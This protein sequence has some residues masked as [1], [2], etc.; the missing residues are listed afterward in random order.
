VNRGYESMLR[1]VC[2]IVFC[3]VSWNACSQEDVPLHRES[4]KQMSSHV[5]FEPTVESLR[6]YT[7]PDW[8]RDAKFGVYTHWGPISVA[9][10][11]MPPGEADTWY[12]RNMYRKQHPTFEFHK[13]TFGDQAE[14][15]FKDLIPLFKAER[16]DADEWA[17][18]FVKSGARFAGPV[19]IHHD[20][21]AMWDSR[22][23]R[24]NSVGMGPGRDFV[25]ELEKAIHA[26]GL[27][28]LAAMHHAMTWF[29]YEAAFQ[30]DAGQPG[31]S[32]LYTEPHPPA[33]PTFDTEWFETEWT[34]PSAAFGQRWL[35]LCCELTDMY[36]PDLLWHDAALN[37]LPEPTLLAM[38]AHYYNGA[39]KQGKEVVMTY[40][41]DE[42]PAGTAVLDYERG[43]A[44][45]IIPSPWLTDTSVGRDFWY[46]D[47]GEA[48]RFSVE[49]LIHM[50]IDIVSKNG[51][52]LLNVGPIP[53]AA[54]PRNSGKPCWR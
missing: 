25:G 41:L 3:S 18:L 23:T 46:C 13:Q 15:G 8:F 22:V 31:Y 51:C 6:K 14:F 35:D 54:F 4:E 53:T 12:G 19:A 32:D 29:F 37:K 40:K 16:F 11:Q 24:W 49:E 2:V 17:D 52:L 28:F 43:A 39:A 36:S 1:V 26:R 50:L 10:A 38:T 7:C 45:D 21:F 33:D 44:G 30:Y 48:N 34:P 5:P 9:T 47:A 42:L 27:K 20:N